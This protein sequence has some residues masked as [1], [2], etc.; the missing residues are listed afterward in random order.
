MQKFVT[1]GETMVQYNAEY[2][3]EFDPNEQYFLDVAGAESNVAINLSK[4]TKNLVEIFWISRLGEDEAGHLIH[5]TLS[6][7]IKIAA[8]IYKGEKTG[9]SYLNHH[10]DGRHLKR[11]LREGSAASEIPFQQV[12]KHLEGADILH[13]TGITPALSKTNLETT[14]QI[15]ELCNEMDI[16]VCLDVNYREQLWTPEQAKNT[17]NRLLPNINIFKVGRDEA[18]TIWQLKYSADEY[19]AYFYQKLSMLTIVTD[20]KSGAVLFNGTDYIREKT[21]EIEVVDPIGAGD[22]F[23]AGFLGTLMRHDIP[24]RQLL[25]SNSRNQITQLT[26]ALK[27]GNLCGALTCTK[28]GDTAAMPTLSEIED[29]VGLLES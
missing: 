8:P 10:A 12:K 16:P 18:E 22:A 21:I 24:L 17:L 27:V 11:Y 2:T 29:F 13:V 14:F 26:K 23:V 25:K 19:A 28:K 9:I 20:G 5:N 3:G 15:I 6:K 7:E 1:F 4:I